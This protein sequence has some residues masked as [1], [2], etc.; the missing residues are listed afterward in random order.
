MGGGSMN[1]SSLLKFLIINQKLNLSSKEIFKIS[2]KIGSDVVIG[3]QKKTSILYGNGKLKNLNNKINLYTLLTDY[4][5]FG[6]KIC[7]I[8]SPEYWQFILVWWPC[9]KIVPKY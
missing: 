8:G 4:N 6:T 9:V 5:L 3:M 7:R 1:A 2:S